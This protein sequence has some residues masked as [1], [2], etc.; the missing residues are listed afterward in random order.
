[1]YAAAHEADALAGGAEGRGTAEPAVLLA[2]WQR[3][4]PLQPVAWD[5]EMLA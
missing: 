4:Q 5:V 3:Q 1:M 2:L